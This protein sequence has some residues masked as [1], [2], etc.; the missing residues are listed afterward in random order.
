MTDESGERR[1]DRGREEKQECEEREE[2][3]I[4]SYCVTFTIILP[5]SYSLR[6]PALSCTVSR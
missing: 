6:L 5:P 2:V 1:A 3:G 4:L